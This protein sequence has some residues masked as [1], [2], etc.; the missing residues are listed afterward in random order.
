MLGTSLDDLDNL[1]E[2]EEIE[3][4]SFGITDWLGVLLPPFRSQTY[5][6]YKKGRRV[7]ENNSDITIIMRKLQ[8]FEMFKRLILDKEQERLFRSLPKP[9]LVN[10]DI[11]EEEVEEDEDE[12]ENYDLN[13]ETM[14]R[15]TI[16]KLKSNFDRQ[17]G[18]DR[19]SVGNMNKNGNSGDFKER[20]MTKLEMQVESDIAYSD[21]KKRKTDDMITKK[22]VKAYESTIMR[23]KKPERRGTTLAGF[24]TEKQKKSDFMR[25]MALSSKEENEDDSKSFKSG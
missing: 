22:L 24:S 21:L 1:S 11:V 7:I 6:L 25:E 23:S 18:A 16:Q 20:K 15:I 2:D 10:L 13:E 12:E 8:E 9:N 17:F 3:Q 4:L 14:R 19:S 5:D